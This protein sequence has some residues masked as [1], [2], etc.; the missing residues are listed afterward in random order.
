MKRACAAAALALLLAAG[1]AAAQTGVATTAGVNSTANARIDAFGVDN[2][3]P[4][5]GNV[6]TFS[7][8]VRNSGNVP[9]N[10]SARVTVTPPAGPPFLL[11]HKTELRGKNE[12]LP[13]Q[14][15][16][17]NCTAQ[18]GAWSARL[19]ALVNGTVSDTRDIAYTVT[20]AAAPQAAPAAGG[21]GGG[22]G[23]A[24]PA[25]VSIVAPIP[26]P[27]SDAIRFASQPALVEARPGDGKALDLSI[28][29]I[30]NRLLALQIE[31][32]VSEEWLLV[33]P[34]TLALQPGEKGF[35]RAALSPPVEARAGDYRIALRFSEA[36][37]PVADTF[38]FLRL[39]V[40]P[41][42]APGAPMAFRN[43]E[44]DTEK[45]QARVG[46][47]VRNGERP[48]AKVELVEEISKVL[49][50]RASDIAFIVPPEVLE[51]D[52]KVRWSL[53]GLLP[54]ETRTLA[55][56]LPG[57]LPEWSPYVNFPVKQLTAT[58]EEG[59]PGLKVEASAEPMVPG[60]TGRLRLSLENAGAA[61]LEVRGRLDV[62]PGWGASPGEFS[63]VV[64]RGARREVSFS[65]SV[66][67][68][69]P[70]GTQT[71]TLTLTSDGAVRVIAVEVVV[72]VAGAG[73]GPEAL[74]S[75][76][77]ALAVGLL[78]LALLVSRQVRRAFERLVRL[79][80]MRRVK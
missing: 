52:P 48:V 35:I 71:L 65:V 37:V 32:L 40:P 61:L 53:L 66:P 29:N 80:T 56:T 72:G 2:P 6:V 77:A 41:P 11:D 26:A 24:A 59:G 1:L 42:G 34:R 62:P 79:E 23:A 60:R 12:T 57:L 43:V 28:V 46:L 18:A 4:L 58:F 76:A 38:F 10:I 31:P 51:P 3:A 63:A 15:G 14:F 69:A 67:A 74:A 16:C 78:A 22:G 5:A 47:E 33:A 39:K 45:K 19:E 68:D 55:Y 21:G 9:G 25:P 7:S 27:S 75:M 70:S 20:V 49:A 8:T 54:N 30:L 36:G 50:A 73:I 13:T 17:G 64:D 44:L